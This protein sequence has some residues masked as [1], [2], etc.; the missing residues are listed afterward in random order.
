MKRIGVDVAQLKDRHCLLKKGVNLMWKFTRHEGRLTETKK[1]TNDPH[2]HHSQQVG[3]Q[4]S[5]KTGEM[6]TINL[7]LSS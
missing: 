1:D 2:Q 7:V 6:E 5:T 4:L 3:G